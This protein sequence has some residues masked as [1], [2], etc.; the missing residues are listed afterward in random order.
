LH[1]LRVNGERVLCENQFSED[2]IAGFVRLVEAKSD[3]SLLTLGKMRA[4]AHL[5][6]KRT[7]VHRTVY[8]DEF[9]A[10]PM[11]MLAEICT[12]SGLTAHPTGSGVWL[13]KRDGRSV[14]SV[15]LA[16]GRGVRRLE[17]LEP[18]L[19]Q[20]CNSIGEASLSEP[21]CVLLA[22]VLPG[23]V[24]PDH[25]DLIADEAGDDLVGGPARPDILMTTD[26]SLLER[27]GRWCDAA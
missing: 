17:A 18:A 14:C 25:L 23:V 5:D 15:L 13:L 6:T 3:L 11:A 1:F 22:G 8:E 2:K 4:Y 7:Y 20:I 21:D 27:F 24:M 19:R 10:E 26:P 12:Q 16:S 9:I